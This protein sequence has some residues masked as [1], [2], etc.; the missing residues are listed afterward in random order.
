MKGFLGF[1]DRAWS[2]DTWSAEENEPFLGADHSEIIKEK[3]TLQASE[4]RKSRARTLLI[5]KLTMAF[6][7][8]AIVAVCIRGVVGSTKEG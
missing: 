3:D 7:T 1:S 8:A 4:L 5:V 2:E 6:L